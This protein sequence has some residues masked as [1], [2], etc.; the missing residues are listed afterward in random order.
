MYQA[1]DVATSCCI[2]FWVSELL[3]YVYESM[4]VPFGK[5]VLSKHIFI[6]SH[7]LM[8]LHFMSFKCIVY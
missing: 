2:K 7:L 3:M 1:F 4:K 8:H 5:I 6:H